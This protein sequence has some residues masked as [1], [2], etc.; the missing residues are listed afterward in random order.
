M[1]IN[2]TDGFNINFAAPVDYR[3]VTANSTTRLAIAYK[4]DGLKV[5]QLDN[6]SLII[7]NNLNPKTII[8]ESTGLGLENINQ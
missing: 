1:S 6:Q 7:E 2:I 4:Y 3:M 8:I 5:F